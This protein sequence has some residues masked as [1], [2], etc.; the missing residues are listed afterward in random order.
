M[1]VELFGERVVSR[2][3]PTLGYSTLKWQ[4]GWRNFSDR[5]WKHDEGVK[6]TG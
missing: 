5:N 4:W 2:G 1:L 6:E 3:V